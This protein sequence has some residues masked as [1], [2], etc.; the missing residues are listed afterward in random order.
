MTDTQAV[1]REH[2]DGTLEI[3][4]PHRRADGRVVARTNLDGL[5]V[6]IPAGVP[7]RFNRKPPAERHDRSLRIR[8][9][10][11]TH[12]WIVAAAEQ[13][14][15]SVSATVAALLDDHYRRTRTRKR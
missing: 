12:D 10:G 9:T 5:D 15:R 8:I 3:Y 1:V 6:P 14:G 4:N 13:S 11:D 2:P 7:I